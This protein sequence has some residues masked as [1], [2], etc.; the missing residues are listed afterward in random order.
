MTNC[1]LDRQDRTGRQAGAHTWMTLQITVALCEAKSL[2]TRFL[3]WQQRHCS[4]CVFHEVLVSDTSVRDRDSFKE[5]VRASMEKFA[6]VAGCCVL[7]SPKVEEV[8]DP[9]ED[10]FAS[11]FQAWRASV[12]RWT[13][14]NSYLSIAFRA[15]FSMTSIVMIV[16]YEAGSFERLFRQIVLLPLMVMCAVIIV[17]AF[18]AVIF[19]LI[20]RQAELRKT[21]ERVV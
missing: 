21:T 13:L 8:E 18:G 12:S 10:I 17:L 20:K 6:V 7:L 5:L 1:A 3:L 14:G 15:N 2:S 16:P 4:P 11:C 19:F 9:F